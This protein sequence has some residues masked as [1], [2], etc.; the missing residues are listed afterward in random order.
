[1]AQCGK[2]GNSRLSLKRGAQATR[3]DVRIHRLRNEQIKRIPGLYAVMQQNSHDLPTPTLCFR[4]SV[5]VGADSE[6]LLIQ[7]INQAISLCTLNSNA[8]KWHIFICLQYR[9]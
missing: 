3:N 4:G 1:M 6:W 7:S 9:I 5:Y 8:S 2:C